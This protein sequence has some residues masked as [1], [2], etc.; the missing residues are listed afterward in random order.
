VQQM[1]EAE[2]MSDTEATSNEFWVR[3]RTCGHEWIAAY[4]P[5]TLTTFAKV[6]GRSICPKCGED[7]DV[8]CGRNAAPAP[9]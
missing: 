7:K 9:D 8:F 2:G 5:M 1:G 4:L 3:C 6:A